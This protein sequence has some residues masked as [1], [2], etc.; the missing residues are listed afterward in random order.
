[1]PK[2]LENYYTYYSLI[3][4]IFIDFIYVFTKKHFDRQG[5][6]IMIKLKGY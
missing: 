3:L 2:H 4:P 1:M 6:L 5:I